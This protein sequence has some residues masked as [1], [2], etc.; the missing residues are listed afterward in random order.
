MYAKSD[1]VRKHTCFIFHGPLCCIETVGFVGFRAASDINH[2]KLQSNM[3][4]VPKIC[5]VGKLK[6]ALDF[7]TVYF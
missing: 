2:L 5:A 3:H 6:T 4:V 1:F 7:L